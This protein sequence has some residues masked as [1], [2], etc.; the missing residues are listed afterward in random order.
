MLGMLG[1]E[2]GWRL[3]GRLGLGGGGQVMMVT[4]GGCG[5]EMRAGNLAR[6]QRWACRVLDSG[7]GGNPLTGVDGPM[8][9]WC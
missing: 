8:D 4:S 7:G 6:H 5:K 1:R 2:G 3:G 9:G